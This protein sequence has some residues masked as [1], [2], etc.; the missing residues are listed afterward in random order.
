MAASSLCGGDH[1]VINKLQHLLPSTHFCGPLLTTPNVLTKRNRK[2]AKSPVSGKA[3]EK[4]VRLWKKYPYFS[5]NQAFLIKGSPNP[6]VH[7]RI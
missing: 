3:T 5:E 6:K 7:R 1:H 2:M 4:K